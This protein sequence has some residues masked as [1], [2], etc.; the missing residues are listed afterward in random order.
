MI[1]HSQRLYKCLRNIRSLKLRNLSRNPQPAAL[2]AVYSP[3]AFQLL[4]QLVMYLPVLRPTI[5]KFLHPNR[6]ND[7]KG[8]RLESGATVVYRNVGSDSHLRYEVKIL[9]VAV[10]LLAPGSQP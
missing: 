4:L 8:G 5:R 6:C 7:S 2:P 10:F 3:H 9:L 1:S